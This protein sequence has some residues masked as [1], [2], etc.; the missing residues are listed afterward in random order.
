MKNT[1][2]KIMFKN[3]FYEKDLSEKVDGLF[4][5]SDGALNIFKNVTDKLTNINKDAYDEILSINEEIDIM[6]EERKKLQE[7]T[8]KNEEILNKI[9]TLIGE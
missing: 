7:L 1:K 8:D 2:V 5:A 9:I 3:L 6:N 4:K